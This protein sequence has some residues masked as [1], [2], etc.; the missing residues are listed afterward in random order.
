[1]KKNSIILEE[2]SEE[3]IAIT[4]DLANKIWLETY[5]SF[6][7]LD[8]IN[9]MLKRMYNEDV[10]LNE[11]KNGIKWLLIKEDSF[12]GFISY[13]INDSKYIKIL[14]FYLKTEYHR[15]GIGKKVFSF[16]ENQAKD[17]NLDKIML[18]VNRYNT[19]AIRSYNSWGFIV[20]ESIDIEYGK[21]ILNDY[22]M[23]YS[24]NL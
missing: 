1:M 9:F 12:I 21:Y 11:I 22:I 24:I 8:Q 7:T 20:K 2:I 18:N 13:S 14:K 3:K 15:K 5:P 16:I 4:I 17:G 10:I 6:I 19:N 23:E